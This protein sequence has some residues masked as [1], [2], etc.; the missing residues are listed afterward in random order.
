[1]T[2]QVDDRDWPLV[3]LVQS[4]RQC[5]DDVRGLTDALARAV[6][7]ADAES[8]RFVVLLDYRRRTVP[9]GGGADADAFW[10]AHGGAVARWCAALIRLDPDETMT[11]ARQPAAIS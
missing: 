7:R 4:G 10:R 11:V 8:R 1:M 5:D 2:H 3:R 6:C 9:A